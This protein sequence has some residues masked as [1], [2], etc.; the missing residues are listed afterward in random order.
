MYISPPLLLLVSIDDLGPA[1][2]KSGEVQDDLAP[3]R[4]ALNAVTFNREEII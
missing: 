4:G 1:A 3:G 2:P